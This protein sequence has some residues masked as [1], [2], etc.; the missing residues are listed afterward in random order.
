[1]RVYKFLDANWA[2]DDIRKKRLKASLIPQLNDPWEGRAL[3]FDSIQQREAWARP[4]HSMSTLFGV[5]CFSKNWA[6]PLLWSHYADQHR[7]IVLGFDIPEPESNKSPILIEV[8]YVETPQSIP[9]CTAEPKSDSDLD[10]SK[11]LS[12][13]FDQWSYEEE[14]RFFI[15]LDTPDSTNG[16]FYIDFSEKFALREIIFGNRHSNFSE[17]AECAAIARIDPSIICKRVSLSE[18]AFEMVVDESILFVK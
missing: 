12:Y 5:C 8:D 2:I 3:K 7:G 9:F 13:K 14:V 18:S 16:S 1:M 4:W 15:R 11:V 17:I 6:N 10:I